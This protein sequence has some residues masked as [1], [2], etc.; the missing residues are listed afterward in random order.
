MKILLLLLTLFL[1]L[2]GPSSK[3]VDP[4]EP[5]ALTE[6]RDAHSPSLTT[7][8]RGN[9]VMSWVAQCSPDEPGLLK[10]AISRDRGRTFGQAVTIP[11]TFGVGCSQGESPPLLAF[12]PNGSIIALFRVDEP[13]EA[14]PYGGELYIISS[15]DGGKT[16]SPGKPMGEEK[17]RS[18]GFFDLQTLPD[19]EVGALW[20][21]KKLNADP[22][23]GTNASLRFARTQEDNSFG[24]SV[25]VAPSVCQNTRV[26][27]YV[28]PRRDV[29][30]LFWQRQF[31]GNT[32]LAHAS[33]ANHG[34]SFATPRLV[35]PA[36]EMSTDC[37]LAGADMV[38][39]GKV[40]HLAWLVQGNKAGLY[41]ASSRN[42]GK[43]FSPRTPVNQ[44]PHVF[45]SSLTA[46]PN[47]TLLFAWDEDV[48]VNGK[49]RRRIGIESQDAGGNSITC[50]LDAPENLTYPLIRGLDRKTAFVVYTKTRGQSSSVG[51]ETFQIWG[52]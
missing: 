39:T 30:T 20:L 25:I 17:G 42:K 7:D 14:D 46:L 13:S 23:G 31:D 52:D 26:K 47:G 12:K 41:T 32:G 36:R 2:S 49:H 34:R 15:A 48:E 9:L 51:F 5:A 6:I 22:Q 29:H 50:Y 21:E 11:G 28:S 38:A 44:S 18:L 19:G 40:L 35:I 10:Y 3:S 27:L 37:P 16:W 1:T 45:H 43:T 4:A 24:N 8:H 33:S